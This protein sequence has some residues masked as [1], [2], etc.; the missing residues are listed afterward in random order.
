MNPSGSRTI[1]WKALVLIVL[2]SGALHGANAATVRGRIDRIYPNGAVGPAP[3]IA[4]TV[5]NGVSGRSAPAY[6]GQD[7]IYILYNVP[8]GDYSLEVWTSNVPTVYTIRVFD[9]LTDLP[10]ISIR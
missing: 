1:I 2:V 5:Y 7:G 9:P 4:V 3:G 6:S 8:P 10:P